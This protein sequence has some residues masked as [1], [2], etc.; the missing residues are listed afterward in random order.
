[1]VLLKLRSILNG[2]FK[3]HAVCC[4]IWHAARLKFNKYPFGPRAVSVLHSSVLVCLLVG[5]SEGGR[6]SECF[7]EGLLY[8]KWT[9]LWVL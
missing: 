5:R 3:K 8:K 4:I 6:E 1:M 7:E 9:A 2:V